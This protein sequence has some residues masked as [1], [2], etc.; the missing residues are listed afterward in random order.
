MR[1]RYLRLNPTRV[2]LGAY[3][4]SGSGFQISELQLLTNGAPVLYPAGTSASAPG[5]GYTDV[6]QTLTPIKAVDNIIPT[7]STNNR[8]FSQVM[9]NPLTVDMGQPETFDTYRLYTG[10]NGAGRDPISWT[11]EV[12][13]NAT[14]WYL[15]DVQTNWWG[16]LNR[17]A[18]IGE[19]PL[20][21]F[22]RGGPSACAIPDASR[23]YIAAGATLK[24]EGGS[25]ETVGP[26]TGSGSVVLSGGGGF[27]VNSAENAAFSGAITGVGTFAVT[28]VATQ[29]LSGALSL[30][31]EILVEGGTL[32]LEGAVLTGVTNIVLAGG[33]LSG[34][35][36]VNGDLK[37]T[38]RGGRYRAN[39][40]VTGAL[41]V[42]GDLLLSLPADV[43]LPHVQRL[44]AFA[45]ADE[46][47]RDALAA[48]G[49]TVEVPV[50]YASK[51]SVGAGS[52]VWS[53]AAPGTM[54]ILK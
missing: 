9:V 10:L 27:G 4:F 54:L 46:A 33:V 17:N 37:V 52:A 42:D 39:L 40:D 34:T 50:G 35:A 5:G 21:I 15:V 44:F 23:T 7:G 48:S 8:W 20:Q 45:S 32:N 3:E 25:A 53:V 51:V 2:R 26:L 22:A 13:N 18:L 38:C 16:T 1:A 30:T 49:S 24:L 19:W 6:S 14:N 43:G 41:F 11:L 29:T 47:T 36:T 31:G 12:S 28:G